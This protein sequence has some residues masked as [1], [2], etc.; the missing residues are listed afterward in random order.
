MEGVR[1]KSDTSSERPPRAAL[2]I[3][4]HDRTTGSGRGEPRLTPASASSERP[5]ASAR[6]PVTA[7]ARAR[8][9]GPARVG[10]NT[11]I[12]ALGAYDMAGNVKEWCWNPAGERREILG[13]GW[14]EPRYMYTERRRAGSIGP[15][16]C[17]WLPVR[18][19]S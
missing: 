19:L 14:N 4:G 11:G 17:V 12:S 16:S 15:R 7:R 13:G 9:V 8:C 1:L 18:T 3:A 10:A 6:S 2:V 5:P